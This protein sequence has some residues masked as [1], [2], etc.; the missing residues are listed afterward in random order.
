MGDILIGRYARDLGLLN[1]AAGDPQDDGYGS[2]G[3]RPGGSR[4]ATRGFFA[5]DVVVFDADEIIDDATFDEPH[6]YPSVIAA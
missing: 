4:R 6:N 5:A 2:D 3:A 1:S